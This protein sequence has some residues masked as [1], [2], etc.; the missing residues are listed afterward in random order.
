MGLNKKI[1]LSVAAATAIV[2]TVKVN[3][4]NLKKGNKNV[5][6]KNRKK[7]NGRNK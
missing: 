2:G 1:A 5:R 6:N 3:Y 7:S 4:K